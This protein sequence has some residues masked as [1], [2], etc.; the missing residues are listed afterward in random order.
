MEWLLDF[1]YCGVVS[2]Q[3]EEVEDFLRAGEELKVKGLTVMVTPESLA[4]PRKTFETSVSPS[5][6]IN[7]S[8]SSPLKVKTPLV[9]I[10]QLRPDH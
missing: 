1:M 3:Q 10:R 4:P 2:L 6:K 7:T 8:I 9:E 5:M